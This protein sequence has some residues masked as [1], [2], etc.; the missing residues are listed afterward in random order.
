MKYGPEKFERSDAT[1]CRPTHTLN[2][3]SGSNWAIKS[4]TSKEPETEPPPPG[5]NEPPS[6]APKD[7]AKF[8]VHARYL[9]IWLLKW[10]STSPPVPT[11]SI[12]FGWSAFWKPKPM[13]DHTPMLMRLYFSVI[14]SGGGGGASG[15]GVAAAGAGGIAG[16]CG[17]TTGGAAATSAGVGVASPAIGGAGTGAAGGGAGAAACAF[18]RPEYSEG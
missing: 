2:S 9:R 4:C 12:F 18:A 14:G 16:A 8:A 10:T 11:P 15:G 3:G 6:G 17:A 5:L 7:A 1:R 13:R